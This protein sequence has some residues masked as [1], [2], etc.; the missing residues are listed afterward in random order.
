MSVLGRA[1]GNEPRR[2]RQVG[3]L[4]DQQH[5]S[6]LRVP[7]ESLVPV[8]R[9]LL[10]RAVVGVGRASKLRGTH[11]VHHTGEPEPDVGTEPGSV[12]GYSDVREEVALGV[13]SPVVEA[14]LGLRN[15]L[16]FKAGRSVS[17]MNH[18]WSCVA[19][20]GNRPDDRAGGSR[21]VDG[22]N[23]RLGSQA[24]EVPSYAGSPQDVGQEAE[25]LGQLIIKG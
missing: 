8:D 14:E 7:P 4:R 21:G 5:S 25:A 24:D 15:G 3:S 20:D 10:D 22:Q 6:I 23:D 17:R 1:G 18:G 11:A 13:H 2:A 12:R 16:P 9:A 19:A